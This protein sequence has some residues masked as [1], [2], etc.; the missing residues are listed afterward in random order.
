MCCISEYTVK[1]KR[2]CKG[3]KLI[4]KLGYSAGSFPFNYM[5]LL[6][7]PDTRSLLLMKKMIASKEKRCYRYYR[8]I[9]F[10]I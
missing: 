4:I 6:L 8:V 10:Y 9:L 1:Y 5:F 3:C 2:K 7:V